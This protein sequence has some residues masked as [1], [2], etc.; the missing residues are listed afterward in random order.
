VPTTDK[1]VARKSTITSDT[2]T[3]GSSDDLKGL[4]A[5]APREQE[6]E[7]LLNRLGT[8]IIT[9]LCILDADLERKANVRSTSIPL[10][11]Q[12]IVTMK[13]SMDTPQIVEAIQK[14]VNTFMETVPPLMK[15]L[16][17]VAK[18]YPFISG[19]NLFFGVKAKIAMIYP[20]KLPLSRSGLRTL[21]KRSD[22]KTIRGFWPSTMSTSRQI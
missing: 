5:A 20:T 16:D 12:Q 4:S 6:T 2:G 1:E 13:P 18:V 15:A 9:F 10:P 8:S 22:V 19:T 21:S 17:E 14:G 3:Q 7:K 11:G